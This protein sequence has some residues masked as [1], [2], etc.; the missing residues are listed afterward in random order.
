MGEL[1][2]SEWRRHGHDRL[3]VNAPGGRTVAWFDRKTGRVEVKDELL[4]SA[5]LDALA[6]HLTR[7]GPPLSTPRPGPGPGPGPLPATRPG[8][9]SSGPRPAVAPPAPLASPAPPL[10]P[11]H[12]LALHRPGDLLRPKAREES[13][14]VLLRCLRWL[15]G[16]P[17]PAGPWTTGLR[18]E[19]LVGR[20]LARLE[21]HGWHALHSIPLSP[22]WDID[23]L[24]I[25]P[26]GVFSLNTKHHPAKAVWV[27]DH[28]VRVNHGEPRPYLRKSRQEAATVKRALERATGFPVDVTPLLVFVRPARL[29]VVPTL[30][31][32]RALRERD[33]TA[34]G[35]VTGK[36]HPGQVEALYTAARDRRAWSAATPVR[37]ASPT[38][39]TRPGE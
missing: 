6:P 4:R 9:P 17:V 1:R 28:A 24:L 36:L 31:D 14:A 29:D 39:R 10:Y 8:P 16:R 20:E 27:G 26:G 2:V 33:L 37:P 35:R 13:P 5:I 19:K 3:Y 38:R 15:L 30:R 12:D 25:G 34:Y 22:T 11:E 32:V 23:H 21:R 18:G 7:P